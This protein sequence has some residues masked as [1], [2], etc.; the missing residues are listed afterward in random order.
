AFFAYRGISNK[1]AAQADAEENVRIVVFDQAKWKNDWMQ[2]Q[3]LT[4]SSLHLSISEFL[5]I[6]NERMIPQ[7]AISTVTNIDDI[8]S[9]VNS[10]DLTGRKYLRAIDLPVRERGQVIR[11]L[12]YMGITAGSLF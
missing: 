10:K 6:E 3:M 5:A 4:P 8:E 11:E 12:S 1:A 7:Q 2:L 9:Y